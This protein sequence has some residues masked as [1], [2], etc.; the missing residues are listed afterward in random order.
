MITGTVLLKLDPFVI[1]EAFDADFTSTLDFNDPAAAVG[2][3]NAPDGGFNP[4]GDVDLA[5][6]G[7]PVLV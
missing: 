3:V 4:D 2:T 5:T 1:S 7:Q 6:L